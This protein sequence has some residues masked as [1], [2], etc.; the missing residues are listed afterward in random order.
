MKIAT[1]M[2][3]GVGVIAAVGLIAALGTAPAAFAHTQHYYI[4]YSDGLNR[5]TQDYYGHTY[6]GPYCPT[7]QSHTSN[8]CAGFAD[9][10]NTQWS[11]LHSHYYY[12]HNYGGY[13]HSY[14]PRCAI[15]CSVI[16]VG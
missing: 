14:Q 8:Y 16:R 5:A 15:L 12:F 4:G 7:D 1:Q 3:F 11:S 2:N 10:Y 13:T 9:G 6:N